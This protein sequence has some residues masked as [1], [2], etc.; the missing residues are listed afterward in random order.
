MRAIFLGLAVGFLGLAV[1]VSCA[2]AEDPTA[3]ATASAAKTPTATGQVGFDAEWIWS[4][5]HEKNAA[6]EGDCYF[7]KSF[8]VGAVVLAEVQIAA[9][10]EYEL[11]INGQRASRGNDWRQMQAID[12]TKLIRPGKNVVAVRAGNT[13]EG[14]AGLVARVLIKRQ[15]GTFESF[16]TDNSWKT[17]VRRFKSWTLPA[18]ND[19]DW[20]QAASYGALGLALPWGDEVVIAGQ[21][22]R[23]TVDKEF[24]IERLMRDEDV[25]SL[26]AMVFDSRGN[27]YASQEGGHL[28]LLRDTDGNGIHDKVTTYCDK[29]E[30]VQGIV[31]LGRRVFTVGVGPEGPALYRLRDGDRDGTADE[32]TKLVSFKGSRGEH[33]AHAVRVGPDGLLYVVIGDHA[34]VD[35]QPVG[36]S[37]Y[38]RWYE[39]DLVRPR[40]EDPQGHAVGIPAPGGTVIRTD[41]NGSFVEVVAGGLRNAYDFAFDA[42]GELFTYDADMEWDRGAPWYRPTRINHVTAGAE[43]GWRSGWAKWPEY[44]L[45]SLPP[46]VRL[47]AGSPTGVE[48]YEH[49]AFPKRY[50]GALFACDWASGKIYAVAFERQG[51]TYVG[52]SETFLEGRPLNATDVAVGPDGALYFCTGGRGT[53]GG[54]YRVRWTGNIPPSVRNLG[55]GIERAIRQP[56][57]DSDWA[58]SR[59][60]GV[61]RD[62]GDKW[63]PAL[64]AAAA[65]VERV[66]EERLRAVD[67]LV[68]FGP[69]PTDQLLTKLAADGEPRMR[70]KAARL[71]FAS[72][73]A[74]VRAALENLLSDSDALVRRLACESL[75]RRGPLPASATILPLLDDDDRFTAFAA[76]RVLEHLPVDQWARTVLTTD[77]LG[78]FF[79]GST[80]LLNVE[81][82]SATS[83]V[84]LQRCEK[85]CEPP[86]YQNLD[87]QEQL[88]LLRVVQLA[89][90]HGNIPPGDLLEL[91]DA[92]TELYPTADALANRELVRLLVHLQS[93]DAAEKFAAELA[94]EQPLVERLQIGAYA[95]RLQTG[96]Q[97]GA[98][99]A[100][101]KFYE[102]ARSVEGGYSVGA[103]VEQFARDFLVNLTLKERN[104]LLSQGE[105]WP[106]TALSILAGLPEDPHEKTLE[107]IRNLDDRVRPLCAEDD[108]QRRL[109]VGII[110]VLG[111]V[112]E[113]ESA[114]HLH[115]VYRDEPEY[116]SPA[117]M[118]LSQRPEG[119]NWAY[120]VDA[121]KTAQGVAAEELLVALTKV[122]QRPRDAQPYRSAI[123][124]GLASPNPSHAL[125]LLEHWTRRTAASAGS[126]DD[127]LASWQRWYAEKFPDAPPAALPEDGGG[128]KW[129][130]EELLI[131]LESPAGKDGD[132][133][134]GRL[135]FSKAQCAAC[136]RV[137]TNG[138]SIG[139]DLTTVARRFQRK[140]ILESIVYP[141]HV[142]SDQYASRIVSTNGRT[143]EGMVVQ[144]RTGGVT[145]LLPSGKKVDV[146]R[147]DVDGIRPSSVSAMPTGL[148]NPLSLEDVADLFAYLASGRHAGVARAATKSGQ[149]A[150]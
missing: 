23:F 3:A 38:H 115:R 81:R 17:S 22:A 75:L 102:E 136:H 33:G 141:N 5:A 59:V 50:H 79:Q 139:P 99:V 93:I 49:F 144:N 1:G 111:R 96:W 10:N 35:A 40:Y 138:E 77:N 39:G 21:G 100:M 145:V 62:Q 43:M 126:E 68:T 85:L 123:L 6:P 32:I 122:P 56:Q 7:R 24:E 135:A 67:L 4:P 143:L 13:S 37:A 133:Q 16:S 128:D 118:S 11:F 66:L 101:V 95:A 124:L 2:R 119:E 14:S 82:L 78:W 113:Q 148:L 34:R 27:I 65:D 114:A 26:I 53:D 20:I 63:G 19:R 86:T 90:L 150:R 55:D 142:I 28:L 117:A 104:N 137:G 94:K 109:R 127:Q 44:F 121:L 116:R 132:P 42:D 146:A 76:R 134:R 48:F 106:A 110:A 80:A 58:R 45:D 98:K 31:A 107:I 73:D 29:I 131:Y 74:Q 54:V 105:N 9:D 130:Y 147:N 112:D 36:R 88:E 129:S 52:K 60:A 30:N 18:F 71:L 25:G 12:V 84:V 70:A 140:E 103:Y 87:R 125:K 8:E 108:A 64:V 51:A 69:R 47:G 91:S 120:L 72:D 57:L 46:A 41:A 97:P 83:R 149:P 89:I 61:K 92:L 15:A